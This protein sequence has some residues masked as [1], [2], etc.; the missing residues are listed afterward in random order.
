[1][2]A[3]AEARRV[4][5]TAAWKVRQLT[6]RSYTPAEGPELWRGS[7]R[8]ERPSTAGSEQRAGRDGPTVSDDVRLARSPTAAYLAKGDGQL[9]PEKWPAM[10][11]AGSRGGHAAPFSNFALDLYPGSREGNTSLLLVPDDIGA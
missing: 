3:E 11:R 7:L 6:E 8:H 1:M 4:L 2:T 10:L 5:P 9:A